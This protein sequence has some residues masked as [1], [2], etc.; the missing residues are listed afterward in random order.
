MEQPIIM[1]LV[2]EPEKMDFFT[3]NN[4][5]NTK[6]IEINRGVTII[7]PIIEGGSRIT[8]IGSIEM[9]SAATNDIMKGL[10]PY[11]YISMYSI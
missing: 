5:S 9:V 2:I 1:K 11:K 3:S 6:R 4:M 10:M 7:L 8:I